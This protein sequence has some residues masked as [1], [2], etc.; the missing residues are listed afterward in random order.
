MILPRPRSRM[1]GATVLVRMKAPTRLMRSTWAKSAALMS[2]SGERRRIA[3]ELT[4][5]STPPCSARAAPTNRDTSA[6]L[7]TSPLTADAVPPALRM[8][9]TASAR[10]SGRRPKTTTLAPSA[11]NSSAVARPMPVPPP[12]T[13]ATLPS[14]LAMVVAPAEGLHGTARTP[15]LSRR[16]PGGAEVHEGLIVVIGASGRY[17]RFR[18]VPHRLLTAQPLEPSRAEEDPAEHAPHVG[19]DERGVLA[20]GEGE[21]GARRVT[22]DAAQALEGG[23]VIG[24][25]AGVAG[26][27]LAGDAVQAP[28]A[29]IVAE[30]APRLR[31][32]ARAGPG[33]VLEGGIAREELLVLGDDAIHL[34][35]LEHDLRDED[36]VGLARPAPRQVAAVPGVPAE[37]A[38]LEDARRLLVGELHAGHCGRERR[39]SQVDFR[40][41]HVKM[42]PCPIR[43]R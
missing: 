11:A 14:S 8:A 1:M 13:S 41:K 43:F 20:V 33:E 37:E 38:P 2:R 19:I 25:L 10:G 17:Q 16:A 42:G 21:D 7:P 34:G 39:P 35:L 27:R 12:A 4:R 31:H 5:T 15:G 22:A 6:S 28:R 36:A 3:A 40:E 26:H 18:E 30:R 24:K 29:P 9:S 23:P 32:V